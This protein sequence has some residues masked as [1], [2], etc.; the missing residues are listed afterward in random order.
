MQEKIKDCFVFLLML[1]LLPLM[2]FLA[3][4]IFAHPIYYSRVMLGCIAV[5]LFISY[6][7]IYVIN[8][9]SLLRVF[10]LIF[11]AFSLEI[12]FS[13]AQTLKMEYEHEERVA[14]SITTDL[15]SFQDRY[16]DIMV[17]GV[18][19]PT[20]MTELGERKHPF[21]KRIIPNYFWGATD[22][23]RY[24]LERNGL[25]HG[26]LYVQVKENIP[27]AMYDEKPLVNKGFYRIYLFDRHIVI[28]FLNNPA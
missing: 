23:G 2:P 18:L 12:S 21:F 24:L 15:L 20:P 26:Y 3:Y 1:F 17:D 9:I 10:F 27:E 16:D 7:G 14:F 5:A 22:W 4:C 11:I 19:K 6:I 13:Y 8:K 25:P 28:R